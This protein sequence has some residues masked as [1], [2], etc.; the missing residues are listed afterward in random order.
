MPKNMR[1]RFRVRFLKT[2]IDSIVAALIGPLNRRNLY[3][4]IAVIAIALVGKWLL[5]DI[6]RVPSDSMEPT[7]HGGSFVSGDRV[8]VNKWAYGP[9]IPFTTHR[10]W[11]RAEPKR[12][13]IV[14]LRGVPGSGEAGFLVKRV[15]GLPGETVHLQDGTLF[16][17]G[18]PATPPPDIA[19]ALHYTTA[20]AVTDA[21]IHRALLEFAR[22]NE[23]IQI[24]NPANPT[25][26]ALYREMARLHALV[27]GVNVD[28][29]SDEEVAKHCEGAEQGAL[30]L[31]RNMLAKEF[32]Y[33]VSAEPELSVVPEGCYFLLG[34]NGPDSHDSRAWGWAPEGHILGRVFAVAWPP[35]RLAD[36]SGFSRTA[37]GLFLL[38]G[39]PVAMLCIGG[40]WRLRRKNGNTPH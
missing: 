26:Q 15:A 19:P 33:G 32:P 29:L 34:D 20:L 16:V 17:N 6:F 9:R 7:L 12:W 36:V 18:Q 2:A 1:W 13:D 5:L 14:V 40:A 21:K 38:I 24:L 11:H 8:L 25:V 30:N 39:L 3:S 31:I 37:S 10:L 22:K 35:S 28:A 27:A 4:W 23:P